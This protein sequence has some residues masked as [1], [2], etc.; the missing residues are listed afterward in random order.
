M[1][2]CRH[3]QSENH[4]T[5]LNLIHKDFDLGFIFTIPPNLQVPVV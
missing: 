1:N 2:K 4:L 5:S 3:I